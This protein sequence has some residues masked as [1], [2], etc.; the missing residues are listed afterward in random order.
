MTDH[1]R[2]MTDLAQIALEDYVDEQWTVDPA[3]DLKSVDRGGMMAALRLTLA[4]GTV[5]LA[6][7]YVEG[8]QP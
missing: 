1:A 4:D 2:V 8:T 5:V 6:E 7:F 3:A